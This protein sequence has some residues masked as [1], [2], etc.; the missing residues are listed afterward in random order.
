VYWSKGMVAEMGGAAPCQLRQNGPIACTP[1]LGR[2]RRGRGEGGDGVCA[3]QPSCQG[4]RAARG[5]IS[6]PLADP[7]VFKGEHNSKPVAGEPCPRDTAGRLVG[8]G[9]PAHVPASR[10]ATHRCV[11]IVACVGLRSGCGL[12][13]GVVAAQAARRGC[14]VGGG[15]ALGWPPSVAPQPTQVPPCAPTA[16]APP[17]SPCCEHILS[18]SVGCSACVGAS[19]AVVPRPRVAVLPRP[20]QLCSQR[21]LHIRPWGLRGVCCTS[22]RLP[23]P[24]PLT[25]AVALQTICVKSSPSTSARRVS[26]SATHAV[27]GAPCACWVCPLPAVGF[28]TTGGTDKGVHPPCLVPRP[29]SMSCTHRGH[30]ALLCVVAHGGGPPCIHLG[31]V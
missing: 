19:A 14:A 7:L 9:R 13:R 12:C 24:R 22:P 10:L 8:R 3:T 29:R 11:H 1:W 27:R 30:M 20:P 4:E 2:V 6:T 17:N 5:R 21:I 31:R 26:R 15:G 25:P 23:Y 28:E 18:C 16:A